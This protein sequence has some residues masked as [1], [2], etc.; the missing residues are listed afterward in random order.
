MIRS[1]GTSCD[2]TR[3]LFFHPAPA[4]ARSSRR[5]P[6]VHICTSHA[7]PTRCTCT[8]CT[9]MHNSGLDLA[10]QL[11]SPAGTAGLLGIRSLA[12]PPPA[13]HNSFLNITG[14]PVVFLAIPSAPFISFS[15]L[16]SSHQYSRQLVRACATAKSS[17]SSSS[18]ISAHLYP[19]HLHCMAYP[20]SF[21]YHVYINRHV[22]ADLNTQR[23]QFL[24]RWQ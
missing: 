3:A 13:P 8:V 19:R 4:S 2:R 15:C 7:S 22:S 6:R 5:C 18:C 1:C 20:A 17:S 9:I 24:E 12:T 16:F 11:D 23:V 10:S 21:Q 14:T